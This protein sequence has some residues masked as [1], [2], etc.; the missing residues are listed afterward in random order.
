LDAVSVTPVITCTVCFYEAIED[1]TITVTNPKNIPTTGAITITI[2]TGLVIRE[3]GCRN[4]ASGGSTLSKT[5]F[6]CS[7][8]AA[9]K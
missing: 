4:H 8:D 9:N 7:Y 2:P 1:Y 6:V 3:N 5:G